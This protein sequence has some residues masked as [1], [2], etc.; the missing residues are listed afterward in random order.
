MKRNNGNNGPPPIDTI[1]LGNVDVKLDERKIVPNQPQG[2]IEY[3]ALNYPHENGQ[4]TQ[5]KVLTQNQDSKYA[6]C[7]ILDRPD[8]M[9]LNTPISKICYYFDGQF[10]IFDNTDYFTIVNRHTFAIVNARQLRGSH[11]TSNSLQL[12]DASCNDYAA[13]DK[14]RHLLYA[15]CHAG[16]GKTIV[17]SMDGRLVADTAKSCFM[18]WNDATHAFA[19]H[20]SVVKPVMH[21]W[22][23]GSV[24]ILTDEGLAYYNIRIS[25]HHQS[26]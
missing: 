5:S 22:S 24:T 21:V 4:Q 12:L 19:K 14:D 18:I 7:S 11:L 3:R 17:A 15:Y 6:K 16:T 26:R 23:D 13:V 25:E 2:N 20:T 10:A 9:L 8:D 1:K